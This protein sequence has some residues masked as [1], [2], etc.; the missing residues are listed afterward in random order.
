MAYTQLISL[1]SHFDQGSELIN[2]RVSP[3]SDKLDSPVLEFVCLER[4]NAVRLVQTVHASLAELNKVIRGNAL[5]SPYV[6]KLA[7]SL[8]ANEVRKSCCCCC[9]C[10]DV[11]V[12]AAA[13][14]AVVC[15]LLLLLL[16]LLC[17]CCCSCCCCCCCVAAAALVAVLLLLLLF[18]LLLLLLL[19]CCCCSCC[20]FVVCF[21]VV[22]LLNCFC[23]GRGKLSLYW[24]SERH[25]ELSPSE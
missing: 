20:C 19:C 16:L 17:C 23:V 22:L 4:Y 15:V 2:K 8:L 14:V 21:C 24:S 11:A 13:L 25:S 12:I 7:G 10:C 5:L 18:L 6:Q 1:L 9:C 3:P